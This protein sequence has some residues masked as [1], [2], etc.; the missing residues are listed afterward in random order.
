MHDGEW[1]LLLDWDCDANFV[2]DDDSEGVCEMDTEGVGVELGVRLAAGVVVV[3]IVWERDEVT[4]GVLDVFSETVGVFGL[5]ECVTEVDVEVDEV[6][7]SVIDGRREEADSVAESV[8]DVEHDN[9]V[10]EVGVCNVDRVDVLDNVRVLESDNVTDVVGLC[11]CVGVPWLLELEVVSDV[12]VAADS[13]SDETVARDNEAEFAAVALFE[14]EHATEDVVVLPVV[15]VGEDFIDSERVPLFDTVGVCLLI[16]F[17][18]DEEPETDAEG[19][20]VEEQNGDGDSDVLRELEAPPVSDLETEGVRVRGNVAVLVNEGLFECAAVPD[21]ELV[22]RVNVR[23]PGLL[24]FEDEVENVEVAV[25]NL[26]P[27]SV[28]E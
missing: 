4:D 24:E 9:V 6:P 19:E 10:V 11:V 23:E 7:E 26:V 5:T 17:G 20:V 21:F 8:L 15:V 22:P 13:V 16:E 27:V 1:V 14:G 2:I 3:V 12:E 28:V 25:G 18:Q